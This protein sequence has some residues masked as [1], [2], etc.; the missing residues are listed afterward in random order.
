MSLNLLKD[1]IE[2]GESAKCLSLF[3]FFAISYYTFF[4]IKN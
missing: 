4:A 1:V 2:H 3:C